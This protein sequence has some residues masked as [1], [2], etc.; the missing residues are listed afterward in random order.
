MFQFS[1][2]LGDSDSDESHNSIDTSKSSLSSSSE[3]KMYL[4]EFVTPRDYILT[5]DNYSCET[6]PLIKKT[7][8]SDFDLLKV[9]GKGSYGKYENH[10]RI[11]ICFRVF[12]VKK[13]LGK[14][15]NTYYAMKVLQK[16]HVQAK[17]I[18]MI[19][20]RLFFMKR[21]HNIQRQSE[22]F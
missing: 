14:D 19:I 10:L 15:K 12:L 18:D 6:N 9:I 20:F 8:K 7:E 4:D 17:S 2:E 3:M 22:T 11:I 16:A 5:I 13:N 1:D 21:I